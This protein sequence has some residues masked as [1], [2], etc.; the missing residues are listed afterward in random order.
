MP[1]KAPLAKAHPAAKTGAKMMRGAKQKAT[2]KQPLSAADRL[3]RLFTSLCAQIDGGYYANAI[4]TCDK[5]AYF[6]PSH[7]CSFFACACIHVPW[8]LVWD[9]GSW[10][11]LP[12]FSVSTHTTQTHTRRSSSSCSK[13]INMPL[14]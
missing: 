3:K 13:R 2:P 11:M 9:V 7:V 12:Q 8:M 5:S 10:V 4:K 1:P 6:S 14:H